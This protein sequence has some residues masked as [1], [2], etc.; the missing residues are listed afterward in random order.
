MDPLDSIESIE[1]IEALNDETNNSIEVSDE[2]I[3]SLTE[4]SDDDVG[5]SIDTDEAN[6]YSIVVSYRDADISSDDD[7]SCDNCIPD[8]E[9]DIENLRNELYGTCSNCNEFNTTYGW[10]Q[11]CDPKK[12]TEGWTSENVAIDEFIKTTQ[13]ESKAYT[14][15]FLECIPFSR[16]ENVQKIGQGGLSI[17]YSA[18]WLDGERQQKEIDGEWKNVRSQPIKVALKTLPTSKDTNE[19]FLKELHVYYANS[20]KSHHFLKVYGITYDKN[21]KVYM[22]VIE[23][24]DYGDLR[25][26]LKT[27]FINLKWKS[28]IE[29]LSEITNNLFYIHQHTNFFHGNFHI[30]NIFQ[31]MDS[32]L[33]IADFGFVQSLKEVN[34]SDKGIY[35]ILP[36]VSPEVLNGQEYTQAA[37]IY[38]FGMIMIE[39][40]TGRPP[41]NDHPHNIELALK[42]CEGLRPEYGEGVPECYVQ[43]VNRCLDSNAEK[44][45]TIDEIWNII[46]T[47]D[48]SCNWKIAYLDEERLKIRKEFEEADKLIPKLAATAY[49]DS[50]PEAVWTSCHLY[51]P[52]LADKLSKLTL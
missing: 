31:S 51:F 49:P 16:F 22:M 15:T 30:G 45:P 41:F 10:C 9:Y 43:V 17:V 46:L 29:L 34:K 52:D 21:L 19:D 2:D 38:S 23:Y 20:D 7:S 3:Y 8:D 14:D 36:Y 24:S 4:E 48:K 35:G 50:H 32:R 42:I 37:D 47:W 25:K 27:N 26:Y 40:A 33:K 13:L 11:S 1:S 12:L 44:R 6:K 18:L 5:S 39:I 28:K